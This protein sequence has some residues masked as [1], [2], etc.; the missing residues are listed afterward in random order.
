MIKIEDL[1]NDF[2]DDM[3]SSVIKKI[4][5]E[6][7]DKLTKYHDLLRNIKCRY[8][9]RYRLELKAIRDNEWINIMN[10]F[11]ASKEETSI[12][13]IHRGG[14][15]LIKL[16]KIQ[17]DYTDSLPLGNYFTIGR[18]ISSKNHKR[19]RSNDR[20][21]LKWCSVN[22]SSCKLEWN[23]NHIQLL[24]KENGQHVISYHD[25]RYGFI[26]AYPDERM[27]S[28]IRFYPVKIENLDADIS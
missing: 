23:R 17:Q 1:L 16:K 21:R 8:D 25:Y 4:P 28:E 24:L 20:Y 11:K 2:E 3:L 19:F 5:Y 13:K 12:S 18:I 6:D 22:I 27:Y 15:Y 26:A 10:Y 9:R 14:Y 7:K